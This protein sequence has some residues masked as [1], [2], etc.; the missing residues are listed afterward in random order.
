MYSERPYTCGRPDSSPCAHVSFSES[1]NLGYSE[2]CGHIKA[3]QFGT[4]HRP[5]SSYINVN[6][7]GLT[8]WNFAAGLTKSHTDPSLIS[9]NVVPV[10]VVLL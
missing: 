9:L 10:M 5:S 2:V 7:L 3:Y 8:I 4:A 1:A 6:Y